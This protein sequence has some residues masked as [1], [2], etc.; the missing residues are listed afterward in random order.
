METD[1]ELQE[2]KSEMVVTNN[3]LQRR[4]QKLWYPMMD[5]LPRKYLKW[6]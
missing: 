2:K 4:Y 3:K 5:E 6:L 1:N